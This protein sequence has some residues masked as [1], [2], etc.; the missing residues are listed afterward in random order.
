[1]LNRLGILAAVIVLAVGCAPQPGQPG[2][3]PT[4]EQAAANRARPYVE[5]TAALSRFTAASDCTNTDASAVK[6]NIA[7]LQDHV[8]KWNRIGRF[9]YRYQREASERH[10]SL[11]FGF[12]DAA[13]AKGCLDDADK[14]YRSLISLYVGA[15]YSGIRDRAKLGID[16]VR[17]AKRAVR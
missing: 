12:A 4:K 1:M 14:M 10:T 13:L 5:G 7:K 6:A 11:T 3:G 15:A 8:S 9:A 17:I 2:G 16:D